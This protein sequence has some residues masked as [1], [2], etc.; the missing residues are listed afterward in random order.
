MSEEINAAIDGIIDLVDAD[1]GPREL[2][3]IYK[4]MGREKFIAFLSGYAFARSNQISLQRGETSVFLGNNLL[5][6]L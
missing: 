6:Y 4:S 2:K 3:N 1:E 5:P